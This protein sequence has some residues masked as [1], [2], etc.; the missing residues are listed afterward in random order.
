M[1]PHR[2]PASM[3]LLFEGRLV[4]RGTKAG[5]RPTPLVSYAFQKR[6]AWVSVAV[7]GLSPF[8]GI[9]ASI[10]LGH[11]TALWVFGSMAVAFSLLVLLWVWARARSAASLEGYPDR[12]VVRARRQELTWP[13]VGTEVT[14][15][16]AMCRGARSEE[17][18]PWAI[19]ELK[20]DGL[21]LRIGTQGNLLP[22]GPAG[23]EEIAP[24]HA[25]DAPTFRAIA[26]MFGE[27]V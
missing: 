17:P 16:S 11:N 20:R 10:T 22:P 26:Q 12:L 4:W 5:G 7:M 14:L 3:P 6:L 23:I 21:S 25:C 2:T 1:T 24:A 19:L 15:E 27:H 13:T 18:R 8:V 9:G